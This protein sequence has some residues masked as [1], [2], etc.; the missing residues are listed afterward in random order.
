MEISSWGGGEGIA[1]H[2]FLK[3]YVYNIFTIFSHQS[4][5]TICY[6]FLSGYTTNII[7]LPTTNSLSSKICYENENVVDIALFVYFVYR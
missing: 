2:D 3:F 6:W 4:S 7:L 1:P 5:V